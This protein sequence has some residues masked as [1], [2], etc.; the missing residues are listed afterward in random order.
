VAP[1]LAGWTVSQLHARQDGP[2]VAA[3]GFAEA[4]PAR[5][6][7]EELSSL[8]AAEDAYARG[9]ETARTD[10]VAAR[11]AFREA[12]QRYEALRQRGIENGYLLYN[13]A[14]ARL[15]AGELG[16]AILEYRRA[17]RLIPGDPAL[18][19]NLD[20]ARSQRR[21][22]VAPSG[23]RAL[24][25]A[26]FAWHLR[27]TTRARFNVFLAGYLAFWIVLSI[28][29]ERPNAALRWTGAAMALLWIAAGCSVGAELLRGK[30]TGDG[31]I[32]AQEVVVRKGNGAGFEP[33]FREPVHEGLELQ[34]LQE[35]GGWY[36]VKLP[37]GM[38][39]WVPVESTGLVEG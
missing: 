3:D 25:Q 12:A 18:R 13:L 15:G 23:G 36:L 10:P 19:H 24:A 20:Y 28:M 11:E 14:N 34:V 22:E 32:I 33:Q 7:S 38:T 29:I 4:P 37:N 27:T 31:V 26:L 9:L 21:S 2:I 6:A 35:R 5:V 1:S 16:R 8:A 39:G 17:Q 30:S